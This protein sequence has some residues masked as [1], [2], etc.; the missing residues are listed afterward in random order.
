MRTLLRALL[1]MVGT[2]ILAGDVHPDHS[3]FKAWHNCE[4]CERLRTEEVLRW[5]K[6]TRQESPQKSL[7][8]LLAQVASQST[9]S[10]QEALWRENL[11]K[12]IGFV[13]TSGKQ[14]AEAIRPGSRFHPFG[15]QALPE[16]GI[17]ELAIEPSEPSLYARQV[18]TW[19]LV[20]RKV[21][22]MAGVKD[23]AESLRQFERAQSRWAAFQTHAMA[24]QFPWESWTN[25]RRRPGTLLE[26]PRTQF[27]YLHP[28]AAMLFCTRTRVSVPVLAVEVLGFRR[29]DGETYKP[30]WGL[31]LFATTRP[32]EKLRE[33]YGL[34]ASWRDFS[35]GVTVPQRVDGRRENQLLV[36]LKLTR[37]IDGKRAAFREAAA[38]Y[39]GALASLQAGAGTQ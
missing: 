35:L 14:E 7:E 2:F 36:G 10:D 13:L 38:R 9:T 5:E 23:R 25:A 37:L 3:T 21:L 20:T 6:A 39:Q 26:P 1:F 28:E 15:F 16:R 34:L 32:S 4:S 27:L 19:G 31:S 30:T 8:E 11:L 29:F 12:R 24:D 22:T 17:P 33:S 18:W